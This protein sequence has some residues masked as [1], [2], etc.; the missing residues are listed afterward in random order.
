LPPLKDTLLQAPELE[1]QIS[2]WSVMPQL[3]PPLMTNHTSDWVQMPENIVPT[4]VM[5]QISW[6]AQP[7]QTIMPQKS[8]LDPVDVEI[9]FQNEC[10]DI[11]KMQR[12]S[13]LTWECDDKND[14]VHDSKE[15]EEMVPLVPTSVPVYYPAFTY[16]I[17]E[18]YEPWTAP[19]QHSH[20]TV[21]AFEPTSLVQYPQPTAGMNKTMEVARPPNDSSKQVSIYGIGSDYVLML[22]HQACGVFISSQNITETI[23]HVFFPVLCMHYLGGCFISYAQSVVSVDTCLVKKNNIAATTPNGVYVVD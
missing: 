23:V 12:N 17:P 19:L 9:P 1:K 10:V 15:S 7:P 11:Q 8:W 14:C 18:S 2:D 21:P 6:E 5:P 16:T 4:N 22:S 20:T 13:S 3:L